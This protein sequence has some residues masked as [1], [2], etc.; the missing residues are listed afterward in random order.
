MARQWR[1]SDEE[2]AGHR[3]PRR[4]AGGAPATTNRT[5]SVCWERAQATRRASALRQRTMT[6][7]WLA[8]LCFSGCA[9]AR[10]SRCE[11][12]KGKG[13]REGRPNGPTTGGRSR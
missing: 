8:M 12:A 11:P 3:D 13:L 7:F 2:R 9:Q 1:D 5:P 10:L 6:V 4:E